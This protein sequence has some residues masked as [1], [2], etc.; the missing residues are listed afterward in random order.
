MTRSAKSPPATLEAPKV[1]KGKSGSNWG[2][3][4]RGAGYRHG[5]PGGSVNSLKHEVLTY[6]A[7]YDCLPLDY[8][9]KILNEEK[10]T[11][12]RRMWAAEHAA[13]YLHA[14][15]A[16]IEVTSSGETVKH[17]VDL[18]KLTDK[19]LDQLETLVN[20]ASKTPEEVTL[21]ETQYHEME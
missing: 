15:L 6:R 13:P 21:D 20:K 19:E 2:G 4:R 5:N 9:L 14:K 10:E 17:P 11:D 16:S 1:D 8:M 3:S 12:E 18:T 7:K